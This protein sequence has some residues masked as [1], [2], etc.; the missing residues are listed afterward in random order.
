MKVLGLFSARLLSS[1]GSPFSSPLIIRKEPTPPL[2]RRSHDERLANGKRLVLATLLALW[3]LLIFSRGF[4]SELVFDSSYII[5]EDTRLQAFT[6]SN[7]AKIFTEDYWWPSIGSSLYR[8]LVTLSFFFERGFFGYTTNPVLY[9]V[10]NLALHAGIALLGYNLLLRFGLSLRWA[11]LA[12]AWFV[13]HPYTAEVVP[14]IVG[15]ADLFAFG[16]ILASLLLYLNFLR[17]ERGRSPKRILC[18]GAITLLGCLSKESAISS[19]AI[20]AWHWLVVARA[21]PSAFPTPVLPGLGRK[22]LVGTVL[23][24]ACAA[25][26][27]PKIAFKDRDG[28]KIQIA[29]DNPLVAQSFVDSR[30][31]ASTILGENLV[32]C[33]VPY[34]VSADYSYSQIRLFDWPVDNPNDVKRLA[35]AGATAAFV[36]WV[37][38]FLPR[39]DP[40][41]AFLLGGALL[42]LAPTANIFVQIGTICADR[43]VYP[44]IWFMAAAAALVSQ[45]AEARLALRTRL[46]PAL[47]PLGAG[48]AL[49]AVGSF[50]HLRMTDWRSAKQFWE[51]TYASAPDSYKAQLAYGGTL[52]NQDDYELA[53]V[54][55]E[56][57]HRAG[58][59]LDGA[60]WHNKEGASVLVLQNTGGAWLTFAGMAKAKGELAEK[61]RALAEA[62]KHLRKALEKVDAM[63]ATKVV[64]IEDG[65]ANLAR[66]DNIAMALA[67]VLR[68]QGRPQTALEVMLDHLKPN[69]LNSRYLEFLGFTA[70]ESGRGEEGERWLFQALVLNDA[71]R[72]LSQAINTWLL[73]GVIPVRK[74]A[75]MT[76]TDAAQEDLAPPLNID[77]PVVSEKVK[78]AA[79]QVAANLRAQNRKAEASRLERL[80]RAMLMGESLPEP[81]KPRD[82]AP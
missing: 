59:T 17:D 14:N 2:V 78:A 22:I 25:V 10:A 12:S 3:T 80:V 28:P 41:L 21:R 48:A 6:L 66:M 39:R 31:N 45:R 75:L 43:L 20:I 36:L 35:A 72:L 40:L 73:T 81:E 30:I 44:A 65:Y 29:G 23:L 51:S 11:W 1:P 4:G 68:A 18:W 61:E 64:K 49:I 24:A 67:E 56:K 7:F 57:I 26:V 5:K 79:A 58:L 53:K 47:L 55:L 9:Q 60:P 15:R 54:G 42:C 82:R 34:R 76:D 38:F 62:E 77:N 69:T 16:S 13:A 8:P 37:V 19:L 46:N 27:L 70:I 32:N 71:N 50:T 52:V 63:N 74:Q 33:I